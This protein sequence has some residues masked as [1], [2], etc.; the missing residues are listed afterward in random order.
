MVSVCF[1]FI[2]S[3]SPSI[4][5]PRKAFIIEK[6]IPKTIT[7]MSR[8]NQKVQHECLILFFHCP[9][10]QDTS[11]MRDSVCSELNTVLIDNKNLLCIEVEFTGQ[12][13]V[14]SP[15][16]PPV[17]RYLRVQLYNTTFSSRRWL[18]LLG[19]VCNLKVV[20]H[21]DLCRISWKSSFPLPVRFLFT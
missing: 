11:S 9:N 3:L 12:C 2:P 20:E 19:Q 14:T 8:S 16:S 18:I 7:K 1:H 10:L 21:G 17:T 5:F 4:S 15:L 13:S 6:G